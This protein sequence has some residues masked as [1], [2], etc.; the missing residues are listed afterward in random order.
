[1]KTVTESKIAIA[2][3][4]QGGLGLIHKNMSIEE[5]AEEVQKVKQLRKRCNFKSI[6]LNSSRMCV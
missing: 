6:L 5:Q 4:R 2:M 3:A 1:M